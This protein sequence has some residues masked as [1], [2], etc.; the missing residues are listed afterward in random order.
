MLFSEHC[1]MKRRLIQ[2]V[3]FNFGTLIFGCTYF[4]MFYTRWKKRFFR[5]AARVWFYKRSA[6]ASHSEKELVNGWSVNSG[7]DAL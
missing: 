4:F 7:V 1:F 2:V 5:N 6:F 3:V